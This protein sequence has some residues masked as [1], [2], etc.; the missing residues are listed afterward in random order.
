MIWTSFYL[1]RIMSSQIN[2]DLDFITNEEKNDFYKIR[3]ESLGLSTRTQDALINAN[4]HTIG[5]IVRKIESSLLDI[6]VLG[7]S[8]L[9][10]I[11][12]KL[13]DP[14]T[15]LLKENQKKMRRPERLFFL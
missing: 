15:L 1:I 6:Q 13:N 8:G 11:K 7:I 10:E 5:E 4:I 3:I 12:M 2:N 9:E 14:T